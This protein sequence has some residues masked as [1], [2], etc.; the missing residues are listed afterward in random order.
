MFAVPITVMI[1]HLPERRSRNYTCSPPGQ[2]CLPASFPFSA[3]Y[4]TVFPPMTVTVVLL[5][6]LSRYCQPG[7]LGQWK[8]EI[9]EGSRLRDLARHVG[10]PDGASE[11]AT[12]NGTLKGFDTLLPSGARVLFFS[13]MSGG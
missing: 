7:T 9:A 8:G 4:V 3:K 12:I 13:P 10:I 1:V 11:M 6:N 5:G 2:E